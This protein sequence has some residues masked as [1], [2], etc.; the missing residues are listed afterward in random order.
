MADRMK[1]LVTLAA[2]NNMKFALDGIFSR[3]AALSI[4]PISYEIFVHPERDPGCL[5]RGPDFLRPFV[6]QYRHALLVFDH[7]GCGREGKSCE[8]LEAE[9]TT[10]L[11]HAGWEARAAAIVI[12]PELDVWVWSGS[13][14]VD[15][16]LGWQGRAPDLRSW[17]KEKEYLADDAVKPARPKE[18]LE[19]ALRVVRKPRSSA[20]YLK[21]AQT[22]TLAACTDASFTKLRSLLTNW[23]PA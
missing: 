11:A 2:D 13:P 14:H 23:F 9:V 7:E 6:K 21:L 17:L 4:H 1:D 10:R 15:D 18:A 22:V 20:I 12:A 8:E 16:A 3:T 19:D 5:T